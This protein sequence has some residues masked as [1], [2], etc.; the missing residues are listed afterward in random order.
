MSD[1]TDI[2]IIISMRYI[3]SRDAN[4]DDIWLFDNLIVDFSVHVENRYII[5]D[6]AIKK[7]LNEV[8]M[9]ALFKMKTFD[10]S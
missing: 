2:A 4:I 6:T 1:K 9:A 7:S 3:A 8:K 10:R 5:T